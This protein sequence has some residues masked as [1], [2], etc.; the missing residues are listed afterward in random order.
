M[1]VNVDLMYWWE[2][3]IISLIFSYLSEFSGSMR[4]DGG[5]G[6]WLNHVGLHI[7]HFHGIYVLKFTRINDKKVLICET[8]MK[9]LTFRNFIQYV[10]DVHV[11]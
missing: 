7:L 10:L 4:G 9:D 2:Q 5:G 1:C 11:S 6:G 3:S 8:V